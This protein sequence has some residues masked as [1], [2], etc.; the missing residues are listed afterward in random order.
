MSALPHPF[1]EAERLKEALHEAFI[2]ILSGKHGAKPALLAV[3]QAVQT[4]VARDADAA[5]GLV[6]CVAM[7][8]YNTAHPLYSAL[9]A[10]LIG[11]RLGYEA[12]ERLPVLAAALTCNL[13]AL[14]YQE[15]LRI[16]R[17][18]LSAE[19]LLALRRHPD[20]AVTLLRSV[21]VGSPTWLTIV[22]QHHERADGSGYPQG[23]KA[24]QILRETKLVALTDMYLAQV[25]ERAHRD[26]VTARV[27]LKQL[28]LESREDDQELCAAFVRELGVYP[29]GTWV[30]LANHEVALV[31]R[32]GSTATTPLVRAVRGPDGR[33]YPEAPWRDTGEAAQ[34]IE[35]VAAAQTELVPEP[36][37]LWP[38]P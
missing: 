28:F 12:A 5:L 1:A 34:A 31:I 11:R 2:Q 20:Q 38:R 21:G 36:A 35:E 30:R 8:P 27:A 7:K 10:E 18:A 14:P 24:G 32:R 16:Q 4:L 23:L 6:H 19:Q 9:L 26:T 15:R 22:K 13:A 33:V 37:E 25:T 29:P 3:A 17:G